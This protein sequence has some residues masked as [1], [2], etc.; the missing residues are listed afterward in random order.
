M[1]T[2]LVSEPGLLQK[3]FCGPDLL[4]KFLQ[5]RFFICVPDDTNSLLLFKQALSFSSYTTA[6]A[7]LRHSLHIGLLP[8]AID[9]ALFITCQDIPLSKLLSLKPQTYFESYV[10]FSYMPPLKDFYNWHTW[11][12]SESSADRCRTSSQRQS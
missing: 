7:S 4:P 6:V 10:S 5:K 3:I 8:S 2:L 12:W 9:C 1:T 11:I